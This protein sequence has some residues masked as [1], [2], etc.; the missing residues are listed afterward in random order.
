MSLLSKTLQ[1]L[2]YKYLS[3]VDVEGIAL[4]S[5]SGT[6]DSGW[7][8]R[9]CNVKLRGG[10]TLMKLPGKIRKKVTRNTRKGRES[11]NEKQ[12]IH[13]S[14]NHE[15][16]DKKHGMSKCHQDEKRKDDKNRPDEIGMP[17]FPEKSFN[18]SGTNEKRTDAISMPYLHDE[19]SNPKTSDSP[20]EP[21]TAT[22]ESESVVDTDSLRTGM[23]EPKIKARSS[24]FSSWLY[25]SSTSKAIQEECN[26]KAEGGNQRGKAAVTTCENEYIKTSYTEVNT[27]VENTSDPIEDSD[28]ETTRK[29]NAD[30]D[31]E[32]FYPADRAKDDDPDNEEVEEAPMMLQL[33]QGCFIGTLDVRLIGKT[34]HILVEDAFLTFE[35]IQQEAQNASTADGAH[36]E[37]NDTKTKNEKKTAPEPKTTGDRV[38]AE[39]V[40]ARLLTMFPNLFLRDINV[41]LVIRGESTNN[42]TESCFKP[43]N[44]DEELN[45]DT[46]EP[47]FEYGTDDSV[48][49]F[50]VEFLSV[51][52]GDDF[53][54]KFRTDIDD[55][56]DDLS[57]D[58]NS[59]RDEEDNYVIRNKS[60][61][62]ATSPTIEQSNEFITKRI[63]TGR[64]P[65]GGISLRI[66]P[67]GVNRMHLPQLPPS[68]DPNL[69]WARQAWI[70]ES[71][72]TVL[73]CSGLDFQS[74]IFMGT[75]SERTSWYSDFY[76]DY[77]ESLVDSMLFGGVDSIAPGPQPPLPP[78]SNSNSSM[79]NSILQEGDMEAFWGI[80]NSA[81]AF[82]ADSNGIQ[83]CGIKSW[84]HR[85]ARR[86]VPI[87]RN[88]SHLPCE[89]ASINW[90]KPGRADRGHLLD[91]STPMPGLVFHISVRDPLEI[92]VD[93]H[94]LDT[95]GNLLSLFTKSKSASTLSTHD[96]GAFDH[97]NDA[98]FSDNLS[99]ISACSSSRNIGQTQ[100][101]H[102]TLAD[103]SNNSHSAFHHSQKW[104]RSNSAVNDY[105][106]DSGFPTYMQPEKIQIIGV[107]LAEV[108]LRIHWMKPNRVLED[109]VSFHYW[110]LTGKCV[111][112]DYQ[113]LQ[114][115]ERPFQDLRL[116]V[117]YGC[118]TEYKGVDKK[119]FLSV[120]VRQIARDIDEITVE[121]FIP[122][123]LN[124]RSAWPSTA[125]AML[126]IAP[127]LESL[128][129][130]KRDRH[131]L[132]IRYVSVI[133]PD[134]SKKS[135]TKFA[136]V[137][138]G[139][140][141]IEI[142]FEFRKE[143]VVFWNE[144]KRSIFGDP[145]NSSRTPCDEQ[146]QTK[147]LLK[148]SI[149]LQGGRFCIHPLLDV[150]VPLTVLDGELSSMSGFSFET[151]LDKIQFKFG[152]ASSGHLHRKTLSIQQLAQLPEGV[153][154]RILLFLKD[155]TPLE[156]AIGVKTESNPFL[157][158]RS[159]NKGILNLS[160]QMTKKALFENDKSISHRRST[161]SD[162]SDERQYLIS[163]LLK[164]DNK[165]LSDLL[166]THKR[167]KGRRIN[168]DR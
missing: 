151:F 105:N 124:A 115:A 40:I 16:N 78:M 120:G 68:K 35:V 76:Y 97:S 94:N 114:A 121:S 20:N 143:I 72:F 144:L 64:G 103:R 10:A 117:G 42:S 149:Q 138:V 57:E 24:W 162:H 148:Y 38:I 127:P 2:L 27:F 62:S 79:S 31:Q 107:H 53:L 98:N 150:C 156:A 3:D 59:V 147:S 21:H 46:D 135:I 146:I 5:F 100:S 155:I 51:T 75:K 50:V 96:G 92:N 90:I 86:L 23:S 43:P 39:N 58:D 157:R 110:S 125:A 132:Q 168:N 167:K 84:F 88:D 73:R 134:E 55:Q 158:Y 65:E 66:L 63:R 133:D 69:M 141:A 165:S 116:D 9:L 13:V 106:P 18:P 28:I 130:E 113:Q 152:Q 29:D 104:G 112:L 137:H 71:Q 52:D 30:T 74:R 48:I 159:V 123:D 36:T 44:V 19:S 102:H 93:R 91:L 17:R 77:D 95:I 32:P 7:G 67:V 101:Q 122:D 56:F 82:V 37:K 33:G 140:A 45:N 108:Q 160:K 166:E 126:D 6:N 154:L 131:A 26:E 49:E 25:R 163:E 61:N 153:R 60:S 4:P 111:T 22:T 109:G 8:V 118:A 139:A 81:K 87:S 164:M 54:T 136:V 1:T 12:D 89:Y 83:S 15:N 34:I 85:V 142:P 161:V 11:E 145:K 14:K 70:E 129:Y 128:M 99:D 41:R 119:Q 80:S 47:I